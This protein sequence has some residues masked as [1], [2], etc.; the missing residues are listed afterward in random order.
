[1]VVVPRAGL[2]LVGLAGGIPLLLIVG[3]LLAGNRAATAND[4]ESLSLPAGCSWVTSAWPSGTRPETVAE[5][6]S[7]SG[8]FR[9][10]WRFDASSAQFLGYS[11]GPAGTSDPLL[12]NYLDP[13][14]L[15]LDRPGALVWPVTVTTTVNCAIPPGSD[16]LDNEELHMLIEIN[17]Y[18]QLRGLAPVSIAPTLQRIA[19]WKA[20]QLAADERRDLTSADHND[21]GRTWRQRYLDCGYPES[22]HFTENLGVLYESLGSRDDSRA[23]N[24]TLK[25]VAGWT[26][27][28]PHD[29]TLREPDLIYAGI[30]RAPMPGGETVWVTTFG[31]VYR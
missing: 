10:L 8:A 30:A 23:G 9:S 25:M 15:C 12:L 28:P 4:N 3:L 13:I 26:N 6:V 17:A 21:P 24:T 27:S 14:A 11:P 1:M 29:A 5:A 31:S 20:G 7:P 18:R 22:A 2:A 16:R 19:S